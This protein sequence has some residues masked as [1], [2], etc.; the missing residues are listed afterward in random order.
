MAFSLSLFP[1]KLDHKI[2]SRATIKTIYILKFL[3]EKIIIIASQSLHGEGE[4]G[5][6]RVIPLPH[7]AN[8]CS[9][10]SLA[11]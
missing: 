4:G 9:D 11:A 1:N 7:S 2:Y 3:S 6:E 5:E 8:G 10:Q